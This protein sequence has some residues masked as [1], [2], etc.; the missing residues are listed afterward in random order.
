[1]RKGKS[2]KRTKDEAVNG[3][4]EKQGKQVIQ[5]SSEADNCFEMNGSNCRQ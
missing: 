4:G 5:G 1:M 2:K 3:Q